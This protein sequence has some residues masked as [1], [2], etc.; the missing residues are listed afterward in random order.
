M[1]SWLESC[2]PFLRNV[3]HLTTSWASQEL[4]PLV[5][6]YQWYQALLA[7]DMITLELP[8]LSVSFQTDGAVQPLLNQRR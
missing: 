1:K 8:R 5:L 4:S 2:N 6:D 3:C 7:V